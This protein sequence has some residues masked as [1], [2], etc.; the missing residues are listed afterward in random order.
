MSYRLLP[1]ILILRFSTVYGLP[2]EC[3]EMLSCAVKQGCVDIPWLIGKMENANISAE[4]YNDLDTAINY[5]CIFTLGCPRECTACPMC[6]T[7]KLQVI[8]VLAGKK[9]KEGK[10]PDLTSCA[11]DC[12]AKAGSNMSTINHC[13]RRKCAFYCFNG[14]CPRCAVFITKLFNQVCISGA[15]RDKVRGFQGQCPELFKAIVHAKFQEQFDNEQK[16]ETVK[17]RLVRDST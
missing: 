12:V 2:A 4:M 13:L 16:N 3:R 10:C 5:S 9:T 11:M 8:E 15:I 7:A 1:L 14:S 17:R 6:H